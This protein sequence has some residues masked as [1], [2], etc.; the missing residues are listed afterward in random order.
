VPNS[1]DNELGKQMHELLGDISSGAGDRHG[2]AESDARRV[3][4]ARHW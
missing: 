4:S 3:G 1:G 2:F